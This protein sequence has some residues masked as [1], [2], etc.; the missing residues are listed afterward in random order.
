MA[1]NHSTT[2]VG[3][4]CRRHRL[5]AYTSDRTAPAITMTSSAG[6]VQFSRFSGLRN[7]TRPP[8]SSHEKPSRAAKSTKVAAHRSDIG[9]RLLRA[10]GDRAGRGVPLRHVVSLVVALEPFVGQCGQLL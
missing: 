3:S 4:L 8:I 1:P 2:L 7:S 5:T 10:D 6:N 9:G